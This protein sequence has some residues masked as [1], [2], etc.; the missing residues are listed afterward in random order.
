MMYFIS[1]KHLR[2]YPK[3]VYYGSRQGRAFFSTEEMQQAISTSSRHLANLALL[4]AFSLILSQFYFSSVVYATPGVSDVDGGTAITSMTIST[5]ASSSATETITTNANVPTTPDFSN[6]CGTPPCDLTWGS[7]TD[8]QVDGFTAGGLTYDYSFLAD[9]VNVNRVK[10]GSACTTE[11]REVILYEVEVKGPSDWEF[12]GTRATTMA[13]ALNSR[14][15]TRGADNVF[16]NEGGS[17]CNNVERIDLVFKNGFKSTNVNQSGYLMLDRGG[18]DTA[19]VVA[20]TAIDASGNPTALG[21]RL[22][23]FGS[24]V[25]GWGAGYAGYVSTVLQ[26]NPNDVAANQYFRPTSEVGAQTISGVYVSLADLGIADDQEFY[27]YAV[28]PGDVNASPVPGPPSEPE[29]DLLGLT[30]GTDGAAVPTDTPYSGTGGWDIM[31]GGFLYQVGE[32]IQT[33]STDYGDA[34]DTGAGTGTGNYETLSSNGGPSHGIASGL[35]FGSEVEGEDGTLQ[36]ADANA[37]DTDNL[38]DEDGIAS[39]PPL[40]SAMTTYSVTGVFT[41]TTANNGTIYGWIDFNRNGSFEA[42]EAATAAANQPSTDASFTLTWSGISGL[43]AGTSTYMRLRLTTQTLT[44]DGGTATVDERS[45][46]DADDGEV[47]DYK[48]DVKEYDYGDAPDATSGMAVNDYQSIQANGGPYHLITASLKMGSAVTDADDGAK[49]STAATLDDTTGAD[50]EDGVASFDPLRTNTTSYSVTVTTANSTGGDAALHGWIDFNKN[51]NFE[52]TE[53]ASATVADGA[54]SVTLNWTGISGLTEGDTYVRLRIASS[55]LTNVSGN[56]G[57]A[58]DGE[59]E[60]YKLT[61]TP[62][63]VDSIGLAKSAS[64][65]TDN[66]DG[67]YTTTFTFKVEN[68]GNDAL[69]GIQITDDLTAAF[70]APVTYTV[71]SL[72]SSDLTVNWPAGFDGDTDKNLLDGSDGLAVGA[73]VATITMQVTI[74]PGTETGPFYNSAS[75][76][77]NS[78]AATDTSD[79]GTDP[80]PDGDDNADEPGENDPTPIVLDVGIPKAQFNASVVTE[81]DRITYTLTFPNPTFTEAF[82]YGDTPYPGTVAEFTDT[83]PDGLEVENVFITVNAGQACQTITGGTVIPPYGGGSGACASDDRQ[84]TIATSIPAGGTRNRQVDIDFN[85]LYPGDYLVVTIEAKIHPTLDDG[86]TLT[87]GYTFVNQGSITVATVSGGTA[88]T[89]TSNQV[90]ATYN[91]LISI[92][93]DRSGQTT[94]G[95]WVVYEHTVNNLTSADEDVCFSFASANAW[96]WA[97][98]DASGNLLTSGATQDPITVPANDNIKIYI[99]YFVPTNVPNGTTESTYIMLHPHDGSTC[100]TGT[101][102]DDVVDTTVVSTAQLKLTKWVQKCNKGANCCDTSNIDICDGFVENNTA[103]PCDYLEYKILFKNLST[104]SYTG[105]QVNDIIPSYTDFVPDVYDDAG[106]PKD[107]LATLPDGTTVYKDATIVSDTLQVDLSA[108][109]PTLAP[110]EEGYI[111]YKVRVEGNASCP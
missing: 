74:T 26:H 42:S 75:A 66:G 15:I 63:V 31:A 88:I 1:N 48:I 21:S 27:G 85:W 111:Q 24:A 25:S 59:I 103:D 36:N 83:I 96:N 20:I 11:N 94:P 4:F 7:G 98:T 79:N 14:I 50:D 84:F 5:P 92:T 6:L 65:P 29:H 55:G 91:K 76:T 30:G 101:I 104:V 35:R 93:P 33:V 9:T 12:F 38:D 17:Q 45:I 102:Y 70:P 86:T 72:S 8:R 40:S 67:T 22:V 81:G 34:P 37:D 100:Q 89:Y 82:L 39:M 54:T 60:D 106:T 43:T 105:L 62:P 28:F 2:A 61:I 47:E 80:D 23:R 58:D 19:K 16:A 90:T 3:T 110:G 68:L 107:V 56:S 13:E 49:Q 95:T 53:H 73:A 108:D 87:Q 77:A 99:R 18:N 10:T 51:G 57:A 71:N 41:N 44:D 109:I 78:G 69:T 32:V 52:T 97:I 46:G 64:N